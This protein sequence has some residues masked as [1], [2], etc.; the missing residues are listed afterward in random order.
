MTPRRVTVYPDTY[1]DSVIQLSGT[2]AMRQVDG[3]DWAAAAMAAPANLA[4]LEAE[5]FDPAEFASAGANDL[6]LAVRGASE[7]VLA[8]AVSAAE[9]AMFTPRASAE[10]SAGSR[11]PATL[12]EALE[13][14]PDANLAVI[15]VPGDYAALE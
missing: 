10:R 13:R 15:S 7:E 3:V 1:V 11:L 6:F 2:R 12:G 8:S 9:A 4:T 14:L 5:G